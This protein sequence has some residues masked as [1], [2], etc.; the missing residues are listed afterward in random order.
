MP[1]ETSI[2]NPLVVTLAYDGLCTFEFGVA[3]ELF[4]LSR[5]EMG[6]NWYRFAVAGLDEGP[7]RATGGVRVV[8]DGGLDLLAEAGTIVI[9]GWKGVDVPV[10]E[11][12]S[13]ALR[14]AHG[15]GARIMT[16]CSGVFALAA[17]GLLDGRRATTH[18]RYIDRLKAAYPAI[19]VA[20]DVLYVDE[21]QLLTSA[22]SA[23]GIDLGLHLVRRDFGTE[24]ANAVARRLVV[25]PHREGGQAQFIE[26][27]VPTVREGQRLG[28][29]LDR[30]RRSL[31]QDLNIAGMAQDA[32]MSQRT[33]LRRFKSTTGTTPGEWLLNERLSHARALL[34]GGQRSIEDIAAACG[35]GSTATL[36]HHFRQRLATSPAAYRARFAG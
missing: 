20:P 19:E 24:F 33:F 13:T 12:L 7:M 15:R 6:P 14:A 26:R 28:P 11:V 17:T 31:D 30:M 27:P 29:L 1:I 5:P 10:P 3:V 25:P 35:F 9:P 34:E 36:R 22:G 18:W 8:A 4:G 23:A 2:A 16:I 32:G 21:G